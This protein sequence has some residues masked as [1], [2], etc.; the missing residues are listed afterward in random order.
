MGIDAPQFDENP[1][2]KKDNDDIKKYSSKKEGFSL[3]R[4]IIKHL[5]QLTNL[6]D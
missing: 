1:T 3:S 6:D 4:I 5:M 2:L